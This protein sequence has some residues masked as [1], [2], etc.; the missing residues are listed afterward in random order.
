MTILLKLLL[1]KYV[2]VYITSNNNAEVN[3]ITDSDGI[4]MPIQSAGR[5]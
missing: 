2:F 5:S 4:I 3:A 1:V